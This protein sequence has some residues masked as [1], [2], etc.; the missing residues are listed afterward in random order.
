MIDLLYKLQ[1][2]L[3]TLQDIPLF[4]QFMKDLG[5]FVHQALPNLP[6]MAS[7]RSQFDKLKEDY[8][9]SK[10]EETTSIS[11]R[12]EQLKMVKNREELKKQLQV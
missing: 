11:N 5:D 1:N 10:S 6:V 4:E 9:Q 3:K 12:I 2:A 8:Q 7:I